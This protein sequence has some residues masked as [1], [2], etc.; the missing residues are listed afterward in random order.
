MIALQLLE[1]WQQQSEKPVVQSLLVKLDW[2]DL[3]MLIKDE[4]MLNR[5]IMFEQSSPIGS[6]KH[7]DGLDY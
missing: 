1:V 2:S 6:N 3:N 5:W 7:V 4:R